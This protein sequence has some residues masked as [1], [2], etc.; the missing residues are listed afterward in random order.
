MLLFISYWSCCCSNCRYSCCCPSLIEVVVVVVVVVGA[1]RQ[2]MY[3]KIF[4]RF[5]NFPIFSFPGQESCFAA[6]CF[7]QFVP[8]SLK[9]VNHPSNTSTSAE[10]REKKHVYWK[11][12]GLKKGEI[13]WAVNMLPVW[14]RSLFFLHNHDSF[15][16]LFL[17]WLKAELK[18]S[19]I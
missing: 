7:H 10:T 15:S 11:S 2:P 4:F 13:I 18:T 17:K 5:R 8:V 6:P 12:I 16:S 19:K 3:K 14:W 1:V 9:Q